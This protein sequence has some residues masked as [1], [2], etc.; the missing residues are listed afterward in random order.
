MQNAGA[1]ATSSELV[2][3]IDID[4]LQELFLRD[5]LP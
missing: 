4:L 1:D 3:A 5:S 2:I